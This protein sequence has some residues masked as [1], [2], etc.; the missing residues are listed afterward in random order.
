MKYQKH[1]PPTHQPSQI[2][3]ARLAAYIDGEGAILLNRFSGQTER[4]WS[5]RKRIWL[6]IA[7]CNT[8]PRLII[9]CRDTFGGCIATESRS[10][11]PKHNACYRWFVSCRMAGWI[12]ENCMPYFII[13]KEQAEIG[14]AF[15][16]TI[17]G[18]GIFVS[19][20]TRAYREAL[21]EKL[22]SMKRVTPLYDNTAEEFIPPQKRGPKPSNDKVN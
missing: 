16:S 17:G 13:K 3:W 6:R 10:N 2:D 15:Q 7:I 22:H 18:P 1:W 5:A 19:E 8:D 9:W 14:L 11:N 21:R 4:Q 20:E 12:L